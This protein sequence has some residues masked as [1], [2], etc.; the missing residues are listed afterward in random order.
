MVISSQN[1]VE[2]YFSDVIKCLIQQIFLASTFFGFFGSI[3]T[4]I[5]LS[6]SYI[7]L[8]Y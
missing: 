6:S 1:F 3:D 4:E 2:P 8:S 7:S 5:D